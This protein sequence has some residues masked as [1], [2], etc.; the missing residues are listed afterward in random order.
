MK[1]LEAVFQK[2]CAAGLKLK[3]SKCFFFKEEIEYLGHVVSGKGISTNPKKIEAVSKWPT[4]R[5]V[6]DVRSFLGFVGYYR[7]FIKNFSRITKPIREVITG[8][9]NQS[10]RA[11][12]KTYI[13]WTDAADTAFEHLK[14]MCVSTPIL[15][16]PNYQ[17]PFT[18][19]T[20]S[21]TDGLG[22]VLYQKQDGK[23]RVIAYASR[24]VSKAEANY[25][26]HKLEFLALK[27]AVCEK[28][29]EYLYGSKP[30]EVFTDNNPLTYVLTSAKLDAC[31]QR[32]VA[33]LANYNFSIKYRC[34]V[35]NTEADALSIIKWPEALSENVDIDN[36]CM[37]THVI[38]AILAGA[39][40]KS[41]LIESVSCNAE[42]IPTELDKDTGKLSDINWTKEQRLDPN[43]G[44]IIRLIESGQLTKRKLQGKDSSEVKSFLR[45]RKSLKLVKDVLYRKSYSDNSTSKKTLWQLVVPKLFRERA[46]LGCHDDVGHQGILRTL[47]LLRERFYWPGMQEEATQHVLKCS[48]CL[49]RKTPPQVAPLQPILVTQP[50]EL[51][52]MDYLSLEPSKGNIENVLVITD[53]FTRY[54]LAYPSKTQTAQATARILWDNFI[55]HY[56]FPEKFISD[57]GRN[58]ESDLI[59]E[60]CKIAGVKKVHT[61]PYHPQG[62][63][64]CER[65]NSTLCNMLGTLS[66]EEKSDWKSYLG[67]MLIIVLS[68]PPLLILHIILMFGRHPRLPIDVEFGL[69]KPNCCDNSSKSRY[70]QK[71][72]R[73]LNYAFQK[74]SKYSDQ[75]ASKYKHSYDK[76]VKGPQLHENDLVLVKIVA[77]KGRHK[78]QDR[79]EPEEYVVIEQPIAGTP[80]YKV[81]PVNGDNVRTLHRNLLLPLGVKL[82]PDY[83]SDDSI[84][85]EDSDEDEE[86]F[87]GDPT[88]RSSDKLSH[89][90]KKEDSRKPK[91]HVRFESSDTD[92]KSDVTQAPELLSQDVDNSALSSNKS[93][94]V[95]LKADEDSSDKLIPMD[96]SLPSQYLVPNL[97]DSYIN[98]ETEVTELCTEIEPTIDDNG[99][100]MQSIN[101]EA[102][103]LV[104]T[105]EFLEFVDTMD[106]VDTSEADESDTQGESV[107][108]MIRQ[109]DVDPKSESQFSS[110]MSYHEGEL[111]SLDPGTDEKELANLLGKIVLRGLIQELLIKGTSTHMMV[112]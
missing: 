36:G 53:H 83:E 1:R 46:L 90:K 66:E 43:L 63:G 3:P 14:A 67:C 4:P 40:T 99:K 24:S 105:K 26:A 94:N 27:W 54:A 86:S 22:A 10:K 110:F 37:D 18:L 58:F 44:V 65:F 7:R 42:I 47:S 48:R 61:T 2:L 77:H 23:M 17:L 70:I 51:V 71:L 100:E 76:S 8:L 106:V 79:W 108:D 87:V 101:S 62:N 38:N 82:E 29:H 98:E 19:H 81:K 33:K 12:K 39:V 49:R 89:G 35:S 59:K 28:F 15:A 5:T 96:V 107:H 9:E 75:Q 64:Q 16:Y 20:D 92:L 93:D 56:G 88:V 84:L 57:Q 111:S 112:M 85:E 68:M 91:K 55:C 6:Y 13:E 45:N 80:V 30:F 74:A 32:W 25:P 109:D 41:S 78:L 21:S 50:L 73:R 60:L 72:R 34:G 95:S 103:S 52:H 31:G 102:E 104:N 11:A 97:D 69:N